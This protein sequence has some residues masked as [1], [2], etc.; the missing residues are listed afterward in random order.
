MA[1]QRRLD[2]ARLNAEAAELHLRVG[3]PE[4]LQNPVRTPARQIPGAVHPAPRR[5]KRI[6][7]KPLRRQPRHGPDSPAPAPHP[8]M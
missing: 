4:K 5:T 7:N 3:A 6:R 1:Q 2:L 8:H